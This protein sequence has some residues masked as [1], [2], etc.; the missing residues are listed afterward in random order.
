[1]A[2]EHPDAFVTTTEYDPGPKFWAVGPTETAGFQ[3]YVKGPGP[4]TKTCADPLASPAQAAWSMSVPT[5]EMLAAGW[6]TTVSTALQPVV[7]WMTVTM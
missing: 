4:D 5:I 1:M 7:G 6:T 3:A 2:S